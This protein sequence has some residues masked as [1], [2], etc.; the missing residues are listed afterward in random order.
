MNPRRGEIEINIGGEDRVL[1]L[2]FNA[3]CS[4]ETALGKPIGQ[5]FNETGGVSMTALRQA[6]FEALRSS[7][8]RLNV[9]SVGRWIDESPERLSEWAGALANALAA[10]LNVRLDPKEKRNPDPPKPAATQS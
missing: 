2:D 8:R 5:I 3:I 4:I 6:L 1:R 7:D 10:A 9:E